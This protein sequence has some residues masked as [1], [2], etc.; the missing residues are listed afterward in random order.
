MLSQAQV[1]TFIQSGLLR[2]IINRKVQVL[3]TLQGERA[4]GEGLGGENN[5]TSLRVC[6]PQNLKVAPTLQRGFRAPSTI[7]FILF[8]FLF[9]GAK[10]SYTYHFLIKIYNTYIK[11]ETH[12]H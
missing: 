11:N 7:P 6:L 8:A 10:V 9:L 1:G 12:F 2:S 3:P 4:H 5:G